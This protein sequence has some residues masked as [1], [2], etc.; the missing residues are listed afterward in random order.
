MKPGSLGTNFPDRAPP[1]LLI[2][3][4]SQELEKEVLGENHGPGAP[5]MF[6]NGVQEYFIKYGG[7]QAHLAMIGK[8]EVSPLQQ[9]DHVFVASKNHK[10]SVKNPYSQFRDGW[11]VEQVLAAPKITNNLTKLMC[12]PTS[13]SPGQYRPLSSAHV[14]GWSRML[15]CRIGGIRT[16]PWP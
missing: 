16:R 12:S 15:H 14:Q 6:D 5:R 8:F 2:N 13:V 4:R 3:Q 11:S 10:H 9:P 1:T 7:T